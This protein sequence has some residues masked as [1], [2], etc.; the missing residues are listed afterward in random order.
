L[1]SEEGFPIEN[2]ELDPGVDQFI[3]FVIKK[4]KVEQ[5]NRLRTEEQTAMVI[6]QLGKNLARIQQ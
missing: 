2:E 1:L 5:Q 6:E 4:L 3:R